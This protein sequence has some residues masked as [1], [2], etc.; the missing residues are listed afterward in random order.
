ML[1]AEEKRAK[2]AEYM[3]EYTRK[4]AARINAQR[5]ERNT[6]PARKA[7]KRERD[8]AYFAKTASKRQTPEA[9]AAA[10]ANAK[11]WRERHPEAYKESKRK[12][13]AST[14]GKLCKAREDAAFI[15]SGGR[16]KQE[17]K[18]ASQPL[19]E[20]RKQARLRY[21]LARRS[22]E[23]ELDELSAFV[24]KEAVD[25]MRLRN[26]LHSGKC[27]WHV[28]HIV[29]VSRGGASSYD[30]LQV[31][32]ALWNRRKSNRHAERFFGA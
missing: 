7:K 17:R 12:Y 11:R 4:N 20:A 24:L 3:R 9:K 22:G 16:A 1:T 10:A 13:Y 31:V 5:R 23:K 14:K 19:T 27:K 30:N 8:A 18:R 6:D 26:K 28:D 32:P 2:R 15:A 21:Q 29:P 25:L